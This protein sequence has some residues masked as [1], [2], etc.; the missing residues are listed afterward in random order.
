MPVIRKTTGTTST[1][2]AICRSGSEWWVATAIA[3]TIRMRVKKLVSRSPNH[4]IEPSR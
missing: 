1:V 4:W 2:P 3:V